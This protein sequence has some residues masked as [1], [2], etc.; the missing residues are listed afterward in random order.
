M[1]GFC[2]LIFGFTVLA[3]GCGQSSQDEVTTTTTTATTSSSTTTATVVSGVQAAAN[4]AGSNI[5][6]SGNRASAVS[7]GSATAQ[8]LSSVT[9]TVY[10]GVTNAPLQG[11]TVWAGLTKVATTDAN[12]QYTLSGITTGATAI[13]AVSPT[14]LDSDTGYDRCRYLSASIVTQAD[15]VD[16][17]LI[18]YVYKS[19]LVTT[20]DLQINFKD[21]NG[22]S[23]Q[24]EASKL[25]SWN[26]GLL[27][28]F[29]KYGL[30]NTV[31]SGTYSGL[32]SSATISGI[33]TGE[34]LALIV[35]AAGE[36]SGFKK[37]NIAEGTNTADITIYQIS[38]TSEVATF[39]GSVTSIPSGMTLLERNVATVRMPTYS[40]AMISPTAEGTA[41]TYKIVLPAFPGTDNVYNIG[42]NANAADGKSQSS[43]CVSRN[44]LSAETTSQDFE[45]LEPPSISTFATAESGWQLIASLSWSKPGSWDPDYYIVQVKGYPTSNK[46]YPSFYAYANPPLQRGSPDRFGFRS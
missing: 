12:G 32:I 37:V 24:I 13:T 10:D 8:A 4:M 5:I 31:N 7:A 27:N 45:L 2:V 23:L 42:V 36:G 9:G 15:T 21:T 33:P 38:G 46:V 29:D 14:D 30:V 43:A 44:S 19:G 26:S 28:V 25:E 6:T 35:I 17:Y 18:K 11:I 22:D 40:S 41:S 39:E 16:F 34:E 1:L 3:L 20:G